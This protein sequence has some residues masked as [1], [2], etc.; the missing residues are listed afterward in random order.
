MSENVKIE[1]EGKTYEFPIVIGSEGEKA[2]DIS[3]LRQ[4]TGLITLDPG[5]ANT[6]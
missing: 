6:G 2:I 1:F 3:N 5:Y 4:K